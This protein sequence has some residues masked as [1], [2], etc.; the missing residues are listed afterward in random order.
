M[1]TIYK[2]LKLEVPEEV[3]KSA[4]DT[5]LAAENLKVS[6]EEKVLELGTG[7]GLLALVAAKQGARVVATDINTEAVEIA[8][9]NARKHDISEKIDFRK[10]NLFEP[11]EGEEFNVI[12]F[13]PPYLPVSE[14]ERTESELERAW[15]GGS[16]GRELIDRF[17]DEVRNHLKSGGRIYL[18]QS[19]LSGIDETINR[20]EKNF[21][22]SV[23]REKV[24]F[25]KIFLIQG[26]WT[27]Q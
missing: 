24:S 1:K 25:E 6:E 7:C 12:I 16:D 11:V 14:A 2:D 27:G 26:D 9:K 3:Y 13:N 23:D 5:F 10:G 21:Q 4:E 17:L 20:L 18:V 15:D 22:L 19:S 8:E